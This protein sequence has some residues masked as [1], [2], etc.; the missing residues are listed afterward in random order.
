MPDGQIAN[1]YIVLYFTHLPI[2]T[3][4]TEL[5]QLLTPTIQPNFGINLSL[6]KARRRDLEPRAEK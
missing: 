5:T 6:N 2:Y 4:D 3:F 1:V